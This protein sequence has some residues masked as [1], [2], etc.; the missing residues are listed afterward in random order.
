[1]STGG[2]GAL[3]ASSGSLSELGRGQLSPSSGRL[4]ASR[5]VAVSGGAFGLRPPMPK[6]GARAGATSTSASA[7]SNASSR[8]ADAYLSELLSYSLDRLRKVGRGRGLDLGPPRSIALLACC[9][10]NPRPH[11]PPLP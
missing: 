10:P 5:P 8:Q 4:L 9:P 7:A 3:L 1:M 6:Q 11:W 2:G